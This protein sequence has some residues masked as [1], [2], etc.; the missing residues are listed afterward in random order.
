MRIALGL[1]AG[2][3]SVGLMFVSTPA[4]ADTITYALLS[5]HCTGG[6]GP[7]GDLG[8]GQIT[9]TDVAGGGVDVSIVLFNNNKFVNT[10]LDATI[11]FDL[12][13]NPTITVTNFSNAN[14]SLL[15]GTA[16]S[17]HMDGTGF[18]EYGILQNTAGGGAGA[19]SSPLSFRV[20]GT[21]VTIA[22]FNDPNAAGQLFAVDILSGTTGNTGAVDAST[23]TTPVPEPSSLLL[24]GSGLVGVGTWA[25]RRLRGLAQLG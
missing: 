6:C 22:S 24:L 19:Q 23:P 20:N 13:G 14:F 11:A 21:G 17:V 10:G 25:R 7:Q 1:V 16:G 4:Y 15:S 12:V 3:L 8:F 9:L 18:F 5:D 2:L